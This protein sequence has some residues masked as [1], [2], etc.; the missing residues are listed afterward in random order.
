MMRAGLEFSSM[1]VHTLST[2]LRL[3]SAPHSSSPSTHEL[4][5]DYGPLNE[6]TSY[7]CGGDGVEHIESAGGNASGGID[8]PAQGNLNRGK[9]LLRD[10]LSDLRLD[11]VCE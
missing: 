1:S 9:L 11:C 4:Y 8:L 5:P 10:Q 3:S 6:H 2:R 7:R